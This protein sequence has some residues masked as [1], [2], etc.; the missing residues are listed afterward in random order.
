MKWDLHLHT[1]HSPDSL[2]SY[3]AII[4]AVQARGLDGIAVTD[5]NTMRGA[6]ELAKLAPFPVIL[7][8][9]IRTLEGEVIGYFLQEEIPRRLP[10]EET[11][12]RIHEQGGVVSVPHPVDRAR[13]PS[14]IGEAALL[15]VMD[16][17]DMI[18]GLNARCLLTGDNLH[19][20]EI[21]QEY[22]KPLTA[23][24]DAHHPI[25]IGRCYVEIEPFDG[26]QQFLEKLRAAQCCGTESR[27]W[28]KLFSG[29]A[30]VA[31][32]TGLK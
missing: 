10:L 1:F 28:V 5:H 2:S 22:G 30:T 3:E 20:R 19:A 26:P 14:A 11:L 32:K 12:A 15:R 17:I 9:E 27:T 6:F 23:G 8:E 31:K 29:F 4:R 13:R 21:A 24:S 25:E 18:E 16:Q 7:A